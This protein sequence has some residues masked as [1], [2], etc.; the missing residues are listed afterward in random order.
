M[1]LCGH[2]GLPTTQ[3]HSESTQNTIECGGRRSKVR[4]EAGD[5]FGTK[6]DSWRGPVRRKAGF[7]R[8]CAIGVALTDLAAASS[9]PKFGPALFSTMP[10]LLSVITTATNGG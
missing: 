6:E 5:S 3:A 9:R 8:R 1:C 2:L 10:F 4:R 7:C